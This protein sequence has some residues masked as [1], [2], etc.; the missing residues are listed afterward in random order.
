[1]KKKSVTASKDAMPSTSRS[2]VA[3]RNGLA[4]RLDCSRSDTDAN[5][6]AEENWIQMEWDSAVCYKKFVYA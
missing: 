2:K 5:E 1:L 6:V 4:A 3:A